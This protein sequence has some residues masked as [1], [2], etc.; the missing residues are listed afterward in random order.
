VKIYKLADTNG[1][2]WNF[3]VC[4][5]KQDPT[6]GRGHAQ[7]VV[8]NLLDGLLGCYRTVAADN[9]F[10]S[11]PL[12][13]R[14]L[15]DEAYLVGTLRPN[16]ARSE[17]QVRQRKLRRGE[18]YGRQNRDGIKLIKWKDKRDVLMIS[19]KPSH[20]ATLVYIGKVGTQ[21][22]RIMK[23][24]VLL[25]YNKERQGMDLSDQLSAYYT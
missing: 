19:S 12:A 14:L 6:A 24:Q 7:T 16:R 25:D 18:V 21:N 11:I 23:P 4:T 17:N 1:Y 5:G 13:R 2:T 22:E 3:L 10:T 20:S 8:I 9:F 15:E